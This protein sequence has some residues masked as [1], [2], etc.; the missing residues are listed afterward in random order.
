MMFNW[1]T[2]VKGYT[3]LDRALNKPVPYLEDLD[4]DEYQRQMDAYK[5]RYTEFFDRMDMLEGLTLM[6]R[7]KSMEPAVIKY[8]HYTEWMAEWEYQLFKQ[9]GDV[10]IQVMNKFRTEL[11]LR[12]SEKYLKASDR[13]LRRMKG[14][15]ELSGSKAD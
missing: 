4:K 10:D 7:G 12:A 3:I 14:K 11:E 15:E 2:D 9:E 8:G 6:A 1:D 5:K 13:V